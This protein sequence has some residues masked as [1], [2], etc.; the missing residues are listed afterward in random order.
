MFDKLR[1]HSLRL[2]PDKCEFIIKEVCY[3]GHRMNPGGVRPDEGKVL[4]VK[5]FPIPS[6]TKQLKAFLG[7]A[8]YYRRFV[9]NFSPIAKPLHKLT[10][11]NTPY[12][13][14]AHHEKAFETLKNLLCNQPLLQYPDFERQFIV[15]C[16][17]SADGI[18]SVLSEG[19][20]GRDL[21]I[22]LR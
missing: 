7:L 13:W 8:G 18:G 6:T 9:P 4:A 20:I 10:C 17:A 3:L 11:K 2:Q 21:P 1:V 15:T 16:D 22:A 12:I 14:G 19:V 5:Y